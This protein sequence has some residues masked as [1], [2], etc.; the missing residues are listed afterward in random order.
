MS[1]EKKKVRSRKRKPSKLLHWLNTEGRR[2]CAV[3]LCASLIAGNL[4]QFASI[5]DDGSDRDF[6]FEMSRLAIYEALQ[7]AVADGNTVDKE[8]KFQGIESEAYDSLMET[9]GILYELFPEIKGGDKHVDLRVFTRLTGDINLDGTY[10]IEGDEEVIFMLNN[11]LDTEKTA[12]IIVDDKATEPITLTPKSAIVVSDEDDPYISAS[13]FTQENEEVTLEPAGNEEES[14]V[15]TDD[16]E[17]SVVEDETENESEDETEEVVIEDESEDTSNIEEIESED[18]EEI[19]EVEVEIEAAASI[20]SHKVYRVASAATPSDAE[21]EIEVEDT[22]TPS[23]ATPSD[24]DATELDGQLY[25]AVL[26]EG[27]ASKAFVTTFDDMDIS[28]LLVLQ[29]SPSNAGKMHTAEIDGIIVKAW[30]NNG[31]LPEDAE[32]VVTKLD[33]ENNA[34]QY[35]SAVEA[36][37]QAGTQYGGMMALDITFQNEA[38]EEIEPDG[39]VQVSIEMNKDALP[40]DVDP[41]MMSVQHLKE[42]ETGIEVQTVADSTADTNGT[43]EAT[44]DATIAAAFEV[45]SFSTFTITWTDW[46]GEYFKVTVHYVNADGTELED[47]DIVGKTNDTISENKTITFADYSNKVTTGLVYKGA[48][49]G[50]YNGREVRSVTAKKDK[51]YWYDERSLTFDMV[52]GNDVTLRHRTYFMGADEQVTADVYLV[53]ETATTTPPSEIIQQRELSRTKTATKVADDEYDLEL[54]ISGAVG[55]TSEDVQV[56]VLLILDTSGSMKYEINRNENT[57]YPNRRIDKVATAVNS[58]T[59][60]IGANSN[61]DA[62]YSVVTFAGNGNPRYKYNKKGESVDYGTTETLV[63]WTSSVTTVN[64]EIGKI[65]PVGGTNY[66]AAVGKGK[67][68][69]QSARSN[70]QKVVVFLTDGLPTLKGTTSVTQ[71]GDGQNDSDGYNQAAAVTEIQGM[72]CDAFYAIGV[73]SD[74]NNSN[75]NSTAVS[76]LKQLCNNVGGDNNS[77]ITK[78]WYSATNTTDLNKAF[79]DIATEVNYMLCTNVAVL[80]TLS[81]MVDFETAGSVTS[82]TPNTDLQIKITKEGQTTPAYTGNGSCN[83]DSTEQNEAATITAKYDGVARTIRLIFPSTYKLEPGWTYSVVARIKVNEAAYQAYRDNNGYTDTG[84]ANTGTHSGY[85]GFKSNDGASV[86]YTYNGEEHKSLFDDPVVQITPGKLIIEKTIT[87]LDLTKDTDKAILQ[88]L[89]QKLEFK[90]NLSWSEDKSDDFTIKASEMTAVGDASIV[91]LKYE[92]TGLSP[93]TTYTVTEQEADLDG[94]VRTT[95]MT[96][97]TVSNTVSNNISGTIKRGA[98]ATVSVTNNYEPKLK[99]TVKK[100]V[101]G[102]M[103]DVNAVFTFKPTVTRDGNDITKEVCKNLDN[104]DNF[105]LKDCNNDPTQEYVISNLQTGDKITI[106]E[107]GAEKYKTTIDVVGIGDEERTISGKTYTTVIEGEDKGIQTDTEVIFTNKKDETIDAGILLDSMPYVV[108]LAAVAAGGTF[109]F[110]RKK[111]EDEDDFE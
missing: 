109:Y 20:S 49:Y 29:A 38:G 48:Y 111:K 58:L 28:N 78:A 24:A 65:S 42:A 103:G 45:E 74:F 77:K 98:T 110:V 34:E 8:F 92:K 99:L 57:N 40:E 17:V 15:T 23:D 70:A 108:I 35:Q 80:D 4:G 43:V 33:E 9:D 37:E 84:D 61:I 10:Q 94:Y 97:G 89:L 18:A 79:T 39:N 51:E 86:T 90:V 32:L 68:Q 12:V 14:E 64:N 75:S 83:I 54:S 96:D 3:A 72:N 13:E 30:V 107:Q 55:S 91:V 47:S 7:E 85:V 82:G 6:E 76:N 2:Y 52:S 67:E 22:A 11:D 95:T 71:E 69:L 100:I 25:E 44:E 26:M 27:I 104:D 93:N 63:N 87:G 66:Q 50:T 59:T 46:W 41:D 5:A 60:A 81:N 53:Y 1:G 102:N 101:T 19:E 62:K 88:T 16:T 56:D 106:V 31:V 73:G 36:L 21:V 105:T